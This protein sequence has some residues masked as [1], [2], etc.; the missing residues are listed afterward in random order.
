MA[1]FPPFFQPLEAHLGHVTKMPALQWIFSGETLNDAYNKIIDDRG[2]EA[3][4]YKRENRNLED[5]EKLRSLNGIT[6]RKFK[7]MVSKN[8]QW[9]TDYWGNNPIFSDGRKSEMLIFKILRVL[10][11][12]PARIPLFEELFLGRICCVLSNKK[13]KFLHH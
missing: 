6:V 7:K 4:W 1:V 11:I 5:W 9:E 2:D 10:F 12:I 13:I 8:K 3:Y